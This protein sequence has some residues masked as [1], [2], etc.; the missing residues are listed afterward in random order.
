MCTKRKYLQ[1][2]ETML[3]NDDLHILQGLYKKRYLEFTL[4]APINPFLPFPV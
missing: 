2:K 4:P 3:K 1:V